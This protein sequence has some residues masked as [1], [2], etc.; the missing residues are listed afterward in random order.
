MQELKARDF[1]EVMVKD[2]EISTIDKEGNFLVQ[3]KIE[4]VELSIE[5][6]EEMLGIYRVE[7]IQIYN[8]DDEMVYDDQGMVDNSEFHSE[9][10]L[11]E[12]IAE[13]YGIS[14]DIIEV[15]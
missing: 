3:C 1:L 7:N 15:V 13:E 14:T 11:V 2:G 10:E 5:E 9:N 12:Y 6:P 8:D 4:R